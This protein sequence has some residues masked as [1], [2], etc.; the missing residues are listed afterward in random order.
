[1]AIGDF[2]NKIMEEVMQMENIAEKWN[3]QEVEQKII[4]LLNSK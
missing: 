4:Q 3:S 1:L 2:Q